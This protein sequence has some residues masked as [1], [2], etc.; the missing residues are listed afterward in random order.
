VEL[1][2]ATNHQTWLPLL[3]LGSL[4]GPLYERPIMFCGVGPVRVG[5]TV[6]AAADTVGEHLSGATDP[7]SK[8]E[9]CRYVRF[10]A[11]P[12]M[13]FMVENGRVVRVETRDERYRTWSGARVGDS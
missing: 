6:R 11:F 8:S 4:S 9:E 7:S 13:L 12:A 2:L 1:S 5:A 3:M 10:N